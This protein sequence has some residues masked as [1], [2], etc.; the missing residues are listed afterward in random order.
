MSMLNSVVKSIFLGGLAL[1]FVGCVSQDDF[2]KVT[3]ERNS[4][5]RRL[6]D[7]SSLNEENSR[8]LEQEQAEKQRLNS[9]LANARSANEAAQRRLSELQKQVEEMQA[10]VIPGVEMVRENGAFVFRVEGNLLF[11]SGKAEVKPSGLKTLKEIAEKLR[12]NDLEIEVAGH[13]DTDPTSVTKK[14]F[15]TNRHLGSAR[16]ISVSEALEKE[17]IAG[18]RMRTSSYGQFRPID[19]ADKS[20]NRRVEIRVLLAEMKPGG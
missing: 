7:E 1:S 3:D 10:S 14:S 15:P 19:P 20:K 18:E 12:G 17:G 8:R 5:Q 13:T 6:D 4:L 16:A 9:E 11:D 2:Q